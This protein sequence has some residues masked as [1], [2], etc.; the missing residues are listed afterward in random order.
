M[1]IFVYNNFVLVQVLQILFQGL[2]KCKYCKILLF[3]YH[4]QNPAT[5]FRTNLTR[6]STPRLNLN[7]HCLHLLICNNISKLIDQCRFFFPSGIGYDILLSVLEYCIMVI[8]WAAWILFDSH[9]KQKQRFSSKNFTEKCLVHRFPYRN[10][11]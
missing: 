5:A 11:V 1:I 2:N 3:L 4:N 10:L 9:L 8:I 6:L 7:L